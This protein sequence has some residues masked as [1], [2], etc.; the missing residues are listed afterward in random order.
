M[1][2]FTINDRQLQVEEGK[3]VLEAALDEGIRIPTLCYHKELTPYGAC[4]L[5]LVE[6]VDGGRPGLEASCVYEV[7]P[8]LKVETDTE[9][10]KRARKIVF[11]LLLAR[12]PDSDKIRQLAAEYGITRTRI[13]LKKK[14]DCIL[15]GLCV[16]VCTEISL[17]HAQS[18]AGRGARRSVQTPFN[19]IAERCI[20]CGACA[21]LCPVEGLRI[22]EAD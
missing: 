16:R 13:K 8:G 4:R 18:F 9:K 7:T 12:C 20:G 17:R 22:E 3:T 14:E 6:I 11:E 19:K 21:Y 2:D 1:V 10:V 5:C 15:C